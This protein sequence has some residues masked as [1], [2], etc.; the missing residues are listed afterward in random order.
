M[1]NN[2]SLKWSNIIFNCE[3]KSS[4]PLGYYRPCPICDSKIHKSVFE[5]S[6]FQFYSD[7]KDASKRFTVHQSMCLNCFALF[8]NPCYTVYGFEVLF[9]EA[10]QSYGSMME[11]TQ[12]QIKWMVNE[13]LLNNNASILDVGCYD[14]HFLSLLPENVKKIGVDIDKHAIERGR[15]LYGNLG[16]HFYLGDFESFE[17]NGQPPTAI[18]MFHVLEH[19]PHPEKVLRELKSISSKT[20]KLII[21]VPILESGKTND[22]NGWTHFGYFVHNAIIFV[23]I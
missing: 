11:N 20:T 16:V 4:P 21:E 7:S 9:S 6:H 12:E 15:K 13:G 10:G 19:L 18:T 23:I 2:L 17:Y 5:L 14:G 3:K 22:I 8:L 1:N